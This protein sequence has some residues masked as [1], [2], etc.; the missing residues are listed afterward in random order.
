[1]KATE[2]D[3]P[4]VVAKR[5]AFEEWLAEVDPS[6]VVVV[7]E[8][9]TTI[10]MTRTYGWS[11]KGQRVHDRVPRNRGTVTTLLGVLTMSGLE[12]AMTIEGG[13]SG[14]VFLAFVEQVL[15][16][17]LQPGDTVVLDNLRAHHD[18]R[19][20]PAIERLGASLK[21]LPPY[22]PDF[23][24]IEL[25]FAKLKSHLRAAKART[26]EAL[27]QAIDEAFD[28]ITPDDAY[29]WFKHCGF[30]VPR[31]DDILPQAQPT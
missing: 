27:D 9:G 18:R 10:S 12:A 3:R 25:C 28:L 1:M 23:S 17:V 7:D 11:A 29:G 30:R 15:G 13:T 20:R 5:A 22:S 31:W 24:P 26:R 14:D 6:K 16:P 4:D 19:I 2:R 21:Y 8:A